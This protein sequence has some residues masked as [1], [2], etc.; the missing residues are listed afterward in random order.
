MMKKVLFGLSAILALFAV[1]CQNELDT[2]VA[3][4]NTSEVTF[5]ISTP[6]LSTR[7]DY[8]YSDG[9]TATELQ[10][11][12]YDIVVKDGVAA[13]SAYLK[14]LQPVKF[15]KHE[16]ANKWTVSFKL[17]TGNNYRFVFWAAAPGA[18]YTFNPSTATVSV[19]YTDAVCN[20]EARDAFYACEGFTVEGS[21]TDRK[22]V[23]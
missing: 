12:V 21:K 15:V 1:S 20:D 3:G 13:D 14:N 8:D 19:D 9:T 2:V 22:S 11:A 17:V 6:E 5:S 4:G 10:C 7:A 23:V 16:G 18:P